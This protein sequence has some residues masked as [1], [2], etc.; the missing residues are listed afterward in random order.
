MLKQAHLSAEVG[1]AAHFESRVQTGRKHVG[2]R[3]TQREESVS[4]SSPR[5]VLLQVETGSHRRHA[6]VKRQHF[7]DA[8]P[9]RRLKLG[10]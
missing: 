6:A 7:Q 4:D 10:L 9:N 5:R 2:E 3:A 1:Q 8:A